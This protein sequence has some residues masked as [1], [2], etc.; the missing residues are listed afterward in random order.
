MIPHPC[1]T[2]HYSLDS[3]CFLQTHYLYFSSH[4]LTPHILI[5]CLPLPL[6]NGSSQSPH[7]LLSSSCS[8]RSRGVQRSPAFLTPRVD[9]DRR[10][11]LGFLFP[12]FSLLHFCLLCHFACIMQMDT[13]LLLLSTKMAIIFNSAGGHGVFHTLLQIK[14]VP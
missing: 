14:S 8:D 2:P 5:W 4:S 12:L 10:R 3:S 6:Q 11:V 1:G 7:G 9:C 13:S